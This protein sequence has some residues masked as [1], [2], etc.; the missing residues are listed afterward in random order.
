VVPGFQ[1]FKE[2]QIDMGACKSKTKTK[3]PSS[4]VVSPDKKDPLREIPKKVLLAL[5]QVFDKATNSTGRMG[6]Q[7]LTILVEHDFNKFVERLFHSANNDKKGFMEFAEFKKMCWDWNNYNRHQLSLL[8]FEIYSGQGKDYITKSSLEDMLH[9]MHGDSGVVGGTTVKELTKGCNEMEFREFDEYSHH[10]TLVLQPLILFQENLKKH[11]FHAK[12][13]NIFLASNAVESVEDC[14]ID[15]RAV[16]AEQKHNNKM[17][18]GQSTG[19]IKATDSNS[20]H[21][22]VQHGKSTGAIKVQSKPPIKH[23]QSSTS[24]RKQHD[25]KH[26]KVDKYA[27]LANG[28]A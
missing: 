24:V 2:Q 10:H 15:A 7:C 27:H 3:D 25:K 16:K 28:Q 22:K 19:A 4:S 18:H 23:A 9:E 6:P 12:A 1:R 5:E 20:T 13:K 8:A 11:V 26:D 17:Q 21:T 14:Q